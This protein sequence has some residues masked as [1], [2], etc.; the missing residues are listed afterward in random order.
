MDKE[1]LLGEFDQEMAGTRRFL[2]RVP[3]GLLDYRPHAKSMPL[4]ALA[5]HLVTMPQWI[6]TTMT[7]DALDVA[8]FGQLP[9]FA[10]GAEMLAAF[11]EYVAQAR[12]AL[13]AADDAAFAGTWSLRNGAE[14]YFTLP[15][16]VV[17]RS[18]NLNHLIHH[19]A[20]LGVYYR[21]NDIPVP[22]SYGPSADGMTM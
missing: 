8:G 6:V 12:A 2:E 22:S 15:R 18:F 21:L 9:T 13:A 1:L 4:G 20:Q 14:V 17:L 3:E 11:D 10:T 7:T 5:A 16:A 19:R